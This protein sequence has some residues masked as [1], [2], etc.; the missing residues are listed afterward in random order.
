[1]K[2]RTKLLLARTSDKVGIFLQKHKWQPWW[3]SP[4]LMK[5]CSMQDTGRPEDG[6]WTRY[7]FNSYALLEEEGAR[8]D[9]AF[10]NGANA[11]SLRV[12]AAQASQEQRVLSAQEAHEVGSLRASLSLL[13][14]ACCTQ[15]CGMPCLRRQPS[16][17]PLPKLQRWREQA[18]ARTQAQMG[19]AKY[20][21]EEV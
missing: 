1:M 16:L 12:P 6:Q 3:P 14:A 4:H 18:M 11:V 15:Q 9:Q 21:T 17:R 5:C 19:A 20:H 13:L 8:P 2:A 7:N 10:S